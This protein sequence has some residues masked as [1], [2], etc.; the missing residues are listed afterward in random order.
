[1]A[2]EHGE[3]IELEDYPDMSSFD[4]DLE[5]LLR[6]RSGAELIFGEHTTGSSL[7]PCT[8]DKAY[9]MSRVCGVK[10]SYVTVMAWETLG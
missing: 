2:E 4:Y 10:N 5:Y 8:V 9:K 6:K 1:M 3:D 7:S